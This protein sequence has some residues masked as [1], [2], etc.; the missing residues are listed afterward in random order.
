MRLGTPA[1]AVSLLA[2]AACGKPGPASDPSALK[3]QGG[4][5][6]QRNLVSD[7]FVPAEHT[8]PHLVN[9]W[10]IVRGP[11]TPW[12][13]SNNGTGTSTLYDGEGVA[14]SLVVSVVGAG[15]QPAAPTGVVFNATTDFAVSSGGASAPARFLF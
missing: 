14:R 15:G 13:V 11:T 12:R 6:L 8:D 1:L 3:G 5:Y 9:G 7:G 4:R 10:G 2:L